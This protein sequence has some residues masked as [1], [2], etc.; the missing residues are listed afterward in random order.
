MVNNYYSEAN[1]PKTLS[2]S[3]Q[4]FF[5]SFLAFHCMGAPVPGNRKR[6][7]FKLKVDISFIF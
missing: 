6:M 2:F 4:L 7:E 3:Y 1:V 5:S